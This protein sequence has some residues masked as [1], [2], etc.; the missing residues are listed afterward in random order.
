MNRNE[1]LAG[2]G[3]FWWIFLAGSFFGGEEEDEG[4]QDVGRGIPRSGLLVQ[5][6]AGLALF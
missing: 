2:E 1:A 4:G 6:R 3:V 5:P